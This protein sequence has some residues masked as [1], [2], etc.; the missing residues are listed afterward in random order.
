MIPQGPRGGDN[1]PEMATEGVLERLFWTAEESESNVNLK[2]SRCF[3]KS[4]FM[5]IYNGDTIKC[6]AVCGEQS[7][8]EL[9]QKTVL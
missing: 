7:A 3:F 4:G 9:A 6:F 2:I 1:F 5:R 8:R